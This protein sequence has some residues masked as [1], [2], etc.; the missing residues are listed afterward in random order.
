MDFLK[1]LAIF[2][3]GDIIPSVEYRYALLNYYGALI[4]G[5]HTP[6]VDLLVKYHQ[7]DGSGEFSPLQRKERLS[8]SQ[9]V[10]ID[11]FSSAVLAY[12]DIHYDT[13]THPCGPVAS[14]I[15]GVARKQTG[16][17]LEA[18]KALCVGMEVLCR[19]GGRY[20]KL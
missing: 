6:E 11:C 13:T 3:T 19:I 4:Q 2:A 14:A 20:G 16:T 1:E 9:V 8:L 12:D 18:A 17:L 7:S 5:A 10:E 15:L